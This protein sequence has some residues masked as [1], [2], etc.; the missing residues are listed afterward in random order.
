MC[1]TIYSDIDIFDVLPPAQGLST[2]GQTIYRGTLHRVVEILILSQI[3]WFSTVSWLGFGQL[4]LCILV[5]YFRG[6]TFFYY[7]FARMNLIRAIVQIR[8]WQFMC[9]RRALCSSVSRGHM[10]VFLGAR[11]TWEEF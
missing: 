11:A 7:P 4:A 3:R 9:I 6:N 5:G 10:V 1:N 8:E 2:I